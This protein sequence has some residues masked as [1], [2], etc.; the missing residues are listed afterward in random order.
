MPLV[1]LHRLQRELVASPVD[2]RDGT[3]AEAEMVPMRDREIADVVCIRIHASGGD[4]VQQRFPN[5]GLVAVDERHFSA[6]F[7]RQFVAQCSR[8]WK[9]SRASTD[10]Y[11]AMGR[12]TLNRPAWRPATVIRLWHLA[13]R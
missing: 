8:E 7:R 6:T 11:D 3:Q 9:A 13:K 2:G 10:D 5:V 4:F 12:R 1:V